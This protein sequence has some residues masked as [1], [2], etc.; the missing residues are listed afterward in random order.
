MNKLVL[1]LILLVLSSTIEARLLESDDIF[2]AN[3]YSSFNM[4]PKGTHIASRVRMDGY[5][6]IIVF[7]SNTREAVEIFELKASGDNIIRSYGWVDED[8]IF[9]QYKTGRLTSYVR[10][11]DLEYDE[12]KGYDIETLDLYTYGYIVYSM[13][14]VDNH[15]LYAKWDGDDSAYELY[16]LDIDKFKGVAR[17]KQY[18]VFKKLPRLGK[19]L[20]NVVQ[21]FVSSDEKLQMIKQEFED[22]ESYSIFDE[23][24]NEWTEFYVET[25]EQDGEK[26][27]ESNKDRLDVFKPISVIGKHR[28]VAIS[29][30]NRDKAVVV[31]YDTLNKVETEIL[32]ESEF[33]DV[34]SA[35][36]N[37]RDKTL[38]SVDLTEKGNSKTI[39]LQKNDSALQE[40]LQRRIE[41]ENVYLVDD[42]LDSKNKLIFAGDASNPGKFYHYNSDT[43]KLRFLQSAMPDLYGLSFVKAEYLSAKNDEGQLVEGF[44]YL[45]ETTEAKSPLVVMPHGGPIG[46]QDVKEFNREVQ[47]LVNR[48]YGVVQVNFRGSSG[49]GKEF[50]HS[51]RGELGRGIEKDIHLI[52]DKV[53]GNPKVDSEKLCIYGQSYGGYSAIFSSILHPNK[54]KCAISAFGITDLPL[55]YTA[56]N[57]NQF[58]SIKEAISFIVGDVDA[59]YEELKKYSP[60]FNADKIKTP[61]LLMAGGRDNTAVPEH[62][63]RLNY[64]LKKLGKPV[65]YIE[66]LTAGHGHFNWGGD[67][68]QY[69]EIVE[70]LDKHLGVERELVEKDNRTLESDYLFLGAYYY[71]GKQVNKDKDKA[72]YYL[73]KAQKLGSDEAAKLLRRLG[74]YDF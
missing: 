73:R 52:V 23:D 27:E 8:T 54:Y 22:Y 33:Y 60:V 44:L 20:D 12:E 41:L 62:S 37:R 25:Y 24:E 4:S 11:I 45:P 56:S 26:D 59:E 74:I 30:L 36:I 70:F 5:H 7:K 2:D 63:R 58:D 16:K 17:E 19:G 53:L 13:P 47:F 69:L 49:Y 38:H 34:E 48:G 65:D 71:Y 31:A 29:N 32:Y 40:D 61:L 35:R 66:Y 42:S 39:Y 46:I 43:D 68:H 3:T 72:E 51:G 10:F 1:S 14:T 64:I 67:R 18:K 28:I 57:W 21:F 55:L 50:A 6:K 9:V 15:V